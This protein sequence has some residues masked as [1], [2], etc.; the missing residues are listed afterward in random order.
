M[1]KHLAGNLS[2]RYQ[3]GIFVTSQ[4]SDDQDCELEH[5]LSANWAKR[6][7]DRLLSFVGNLQ[8]RPVTQIIVIGHGNFAQHVKHIKA[9]G[10]AVA[11]LLLSSE[12]PV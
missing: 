10:L 12:C 4:R 5:T 9:F 11:V 6:E 2:E 1:N 3:C 7:K 8:N